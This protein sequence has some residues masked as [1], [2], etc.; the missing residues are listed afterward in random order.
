VADEENVLVRLRI[1]SAPGQRVGDTGSDLLD[2]GLTPDRLVEA[3]LGRP[4]AP[5]STPTLRQHRGP[6]PRSATSA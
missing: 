6:P 4:A 5:A 2:P 3:S 1:G